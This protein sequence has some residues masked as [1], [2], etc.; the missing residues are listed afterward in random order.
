MFLGVV[1]MSSLGMA[2]LAP[3]SVGALGGGN[4]G[5]EG[6]LGFKPWYYGLCKDDSSPDIAVP[7][8]GDDEE[9]ARFVWTI[10]LNVLVD[11]TVAIGYL[12]LGFVIYGGYLYIMSQGDPGRAMRGKKTLMNAIIGTVIA[13]SAS[14][15][16]NTVRVILGISGNNSWNQGEYTV[17][18]IKTAFDWAYT[19]A[20]VVAV[21]F[22]IENAI[23]Y[24]ISQGDPGK[25]RKATQG[26]IYAVVGLVIVLLAAV[27]TGFV[28]N[29]INGANAATEV[30]ALIL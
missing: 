22:I 10:V 21:I 16:V 8:K 24:M 23:D 17:D 7:A 27:I 18:K 6:Y 26:I 28:F 11:L 13:L 19:V 29:A 15:A 5:V 3:E 12:A 1:M 9:L 30:T 14:V 4:C 2:V 25:T 20:G